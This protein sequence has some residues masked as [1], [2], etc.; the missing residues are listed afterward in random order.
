MP[1]REAWELKSMQEASL[2]VKIKLTM[3]RVREWV[4]EFGE[5]GVYISFSGG[6]DSTVLLH[7]IRQEFADIPA[8]F[9]N[10][11]LEYPD[12]VKFALSQENVIEVR[13]DM[14]FLK[15]VEKYGYP[16]ISKEVAEEVEKAR[17]SGNTK[18]FD[19]SMLG[20]PFDMSGYKWLLD[21]PF[22][23]SARCCDISKKSPM[24]TYATKTGRKPIVATMAC[25]SRLRKQ[26]WLM[27]GCNAF[28]TEHPQSNPM[29]FWMEQDVLAYIHRNNLPIAP[30]YKEV[31]VEN[32]R[33]EQQGQLSIYDVTGNYDGC[34]LKTTGCARTGC[35]YCLFGIR[36]DWDRLV[37][38]KE[39]EPQICDYVM[40]GGGYENGTWQPKNGLGFR[41]VCEWL[42]NHGGFRIK[43]PE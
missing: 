31:V 8:V 32:H 18:K 17:S 4:D 37:R 28:D 15:V 7:I 35:V 24:I 36:S 43:L 41:F 9:A 21:A 10:T 19:G 16:V 39:E 38:L 34:K 14:P 11:G 42:N 6:K 5:D 1:R 30:P 13:P 12:L 33:T 40:R 29:A 23:I 2:D 22:K 27:H 20:T 3:T 25:E 26:K